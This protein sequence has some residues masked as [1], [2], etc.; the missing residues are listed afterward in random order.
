VFGHSAQ[1][2]IS[3]Q[4]KASKVL[5]FGEKLSVI[6]IKEKSVIFSMNTNVIKFE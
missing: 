1:Q 5:Y 4:L 3:S 2:L 6:K